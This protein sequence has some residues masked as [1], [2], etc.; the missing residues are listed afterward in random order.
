MDLSS[1]SNE[2]DESLKSWKSKTTRKIIVSAIF[3]MKQFT[4]MDDKLKL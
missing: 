2:G 1:E 4:D 3:E